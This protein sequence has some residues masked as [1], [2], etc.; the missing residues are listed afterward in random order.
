MPR[1]GAHALPKSLGISFWDPPIP[2][3]IS[4][5][6]LWSVLIWQ[7]SWLL[8]V[9]L[10]LFLFGAGFALKKL[11]FQNRWKGIL[12]AMASCSGVNGFNTHFK[13]QLHHEVI[14]C[15][16][17]SDLELISLFFPPDFMD[18]RQTCIEDDQSEP[19]DMGL[20]LDLAENLELRGFCSIPCILLL[21]IVHIVLKFCLIVPSLHGIEFGNSLWAC[22]W[23]YISQ[24]WL[25]DFL[26]VIGA[27]ASF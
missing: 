25:L 15:A 1:H 2:R 27:V 19:L 21:P 7:M 23:S 5:N 9:C 26:Q 6:C 22:L 3:C 16:Q 17:C 20:R 4:A 24:L 12:G 14:D 13:L 11:N 10:Q 8:Y 18:T